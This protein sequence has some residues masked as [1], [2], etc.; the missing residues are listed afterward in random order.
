[1]S[2]LTDPFFISVLICWIFSVCVHEFAHA[3]VAYWGGDRS[4]RARGYLDFNPLRYI[5]PFTS[6]LLPCLFLMMG[7]VPLPGG[8]VRIDTSALRSRAWSSAVSAAG[9]ASNFL[10]FLLIAAIL[11]PATGLV[12]PNAADHSSVVKLLGALAVLQLIGMFLNLLPVPPLDGFG[13]IEPF[14]DAQTRHHLANPQVRLI[15]LLVLFFV[16]LRVDAFFTRLYDLVGFVLNATGLPPELTWR[17]FY[18]AISG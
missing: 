7:G 6:L 16:V 9:P 1:M 2:K 4:V 11:H 8:A 15:A 3:L 10:L 5:Y 14:L 17:Y 12:D 18:Q 13:I